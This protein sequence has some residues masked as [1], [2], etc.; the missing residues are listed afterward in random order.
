M[1]HL[2]NRKYVVQGIFILMTL[3]LLGK[4]FYMQVLSDKYFLEANN[5]ALRK[6]YVYPARGVILDRNQ[7]ILAQ[8]QPIYDL[9]VTP[10]QVKAFDTLS[11]C[12]I[13]G[14][15][16]AE[17]N[18]KLHDA[19]VYSRYRA[20]IFQ[21]L[22]SV[23]TY[24]ALQERMPDYPGFYVQKRTIRYYPDS[25]A[26]HFLGFVREVSAMDI[27]KNDGYY[28][29]GDYIGKSGIEKFYEKALR[30]TKGVTHMIYN[31]HNVPQGSYADGKLDSAA[32]S[33]EQLTTTLDSRIQKLGEELLANKRGSIV[34]IEPATGE[35]LAFVSS[36]GYNPNQMV[37]KETGKN[38]AKLSAN[39]YQPFNI[40]PISGRYSPGSAFKPLDALIAL[41][42]G[43]ITPSS[44]FFCPGYYWAGNRRF[45]CEHQD[46]NTDLRLALARSCNTYFYNI[47]EKMMTKNGVKNQRATYQDW[48]NKVRKFGIGDTLG[49][50]FPGE[51]AFKLFRAADY[52]RMHGNRWSYSTV[53]S[54]AIGQGE[55][56]TTPLQMANIMAI[57]ANRG[58]YIKPHVVKGI[59]DNMSIDKKYTEKHEVGVDARY[60]EPVID[61]MQ[62]AVNS[63]HGTATE[64]RLP[65]ILMCGKTGT[66]QN[67]KG[68]NHSVFIGFAPRDNPK[69]AIAV[70]VENAGY[71]GAYAA[72]I[73]SYI[74]EKY[75]TDTL[76]G[77]Y[78]NGASIEKYKADN[79][80]PPLK[81]D[82]SKSK[83][84]VDTSRKEQLDSLKKA[85]PPATK[86]AASSLNRA[87]ILPDKIIITSINNATA[88]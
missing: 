19:V 28:K 33:G 55:I 35:I 22:L 73:A 77:R 43:V 50:D 58:Y 26:S 84:K 30:G 65:D 39:P 24:A 8:N 27:E 36:P 52:D 78:I 54:I 2:F 86:T 3:I 67:N 59:G 76:K 71:G 31:V 48:Q 60:F 15:D 61:G 46:G 72:P 45:A 14:L 18:K 49:I 1:D 79:L 75:L 88:E 9:M 21:K 69:I 70:I 63:A 23:E 83:V 68:K 6:L 11:L 42:E 41:Q 4:L 87:A 13:I 57:I 80:L 66:V 25:I 12:R 29:P 10:N 38:L 56:T 34:A 62:D 40:R 32:I 82:F 17:F 85:I 53:L 20:S 44:T 7:R 37:G 51:K 81:Q 47:F 74:T 64:S 16:T 5:N